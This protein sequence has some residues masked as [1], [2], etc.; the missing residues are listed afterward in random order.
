MKI[1]VKE[2]AEKLLETIDPNR[3]YAE[4]TIYNSILEILELDLQKLA[5][6]VKDKMIEI[7][8]PQP[9]N[10]AEYDEK[11]GVDNE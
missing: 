6:E 4:E 11:I 3:K 10:K 1:D 9:R 7:S 5:E 8:H 2:L